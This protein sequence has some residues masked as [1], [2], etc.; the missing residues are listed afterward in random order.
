VKRT[1]T[2][3]S[4]EIVG[5]SP[6]APSTFKIMASAAA[7]KTLS[8]GLYT[9][10][11]RAV[12]R[13][14]SSNAFDSQT[15][16]GRFMRP[17]AE[18]EPFSVHLPTAM[19]PWFS[20]KDKGTGMA[21]C[22]QG[23]VQ[24]QSTGKTGELTCD[25]CRGSGDFDE[26][27]EL[28]CTYF[29]SSRTNSN[30]YVGALGLGSKS[31]FAYL[32]QGGFSVTNRRAGWT[33]IYSCFLNDRGEPD[34][35]LQKAFRSPKAASGVEV[36]FPVKVKD[37][38][39]FLNQAG[40]VWEFYSPVPETNIAVDVEQPTY[41]MRRETWGLR[42][43][44]GDSARAIQGRIQYKLGEIDESRTT[45]EH[46]RLLEMPID[47]FFS[48]GQLDVAASR[49]ALSNDN[50]TVTNIIAALDR[51]AAELMEEVKAQLRTVE[52]AWGARQ[53]L[54]SFEDDDNSMS[55]FVKGARQRGALWGDWGGYTLTEADPSVNRLDYRSL[56]L[57]RFKSGGSGAEADKKR[58][59]TMDMPPVSSPDATTRRPAFRLTF[60]PLPGTFFIINDLGYGGEKYIH[61]YLQKDDWKGA[62][63]RLMNRA[64]F[65][66]RSTKEVT[67]EDVWTEAQA[68]LA[69]LGNPP[70]ILLSEMKARYKESNPNQEATVYPERNVLALENRYGYKW[71][72]AWERA[73]KFEEKPVKFYVPVK[74]LQPT[75]GRFGSPSGLSDFIRALVNSGMF[76]VDSVED[77][78]GVREPFVRRLDKTWVNLIDHVTSR[79]KHG[80]MSPQRALKVWVHRN[81]FNVPME[82]QMRRMAAKPELPSRSPFQRF[83]AELAEV[84]KPGKDIEA[85]SKVV[86]WAETRGAYQLPEVQLGFEA[87]YGTLVARYPLLQTVEGHA[88][89]RNPEVHA[90][91]LDYINMIDRRE[92]EVKTADLSLVAAAGWEGE[93]SYV[94]N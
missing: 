40:H 85:L 26:V 31:P 51:V 63:G 6:A 91:L 87:K 35:L 94:N 24:C 17:G 23:C 61:Y 4:V 71:W 25:V 34:V 27:L 84:G 13:E 16:A 59:G 28:Y 20:V 68:L 21:Y 75:E 79:F 93:Y 14:L 19:E 81:P 77:V 5:G 48:I 88:F 9:N 30:D 11:I 10:K 15:E 74:N 86:A 90:G 8:S 45:P 53:L 52:T 32:T 80:V 49:E 29:S 72:G 73:F 1:E 82:E 64:I 50:Q 43:E 57:F 92:A 3:S 69:E 44:D 78:Y 2:F 36:K 38:A 41:K 76:G 33:R 65:L 54:L 12:V 7:F 89:D 39:E 58:L 62:D 70:S 55:V 37:V 56:S 47:L 66:T 60:T 67:L 18:A 83:C 46:R 22:P 42:A